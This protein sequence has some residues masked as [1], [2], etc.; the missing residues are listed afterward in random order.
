[1]KLRSQADESVTSNTPRPEEGR[2][3]TFMSF[4]KSNIGPVISQPYVSRYDRSKVSESGS[5]RIASESDR[6]PAD[7]RIEVRQEQQSREPK[8]SS[9]KPQTSRQESEPEREWQ[10]E[11]DVQMRPKLSGETRRSD[12][13]SERRTSRGV[14]SKRQ[15]AEARLSDFIS[16]IPP[17]AFADVETFE[18][19][20]YND[21]PFPPPPDKLSSSSDSML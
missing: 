3:N 20:T 8:I 9:G 13:T 1:M 19:S 14:T 17:P 5:T 7:D 21:V 2:L 16:S 6:S 11:M 15:S 4:G 18:K 12:V 10:S